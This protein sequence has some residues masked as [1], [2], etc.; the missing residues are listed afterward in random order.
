MEWQNLPLEVPPGFFRGGT[1]LASRGRWYDGNL[2]RWRDG[3]MQPVGGEAA[4]PGS[5][6]GN[7]Q[8][9]DAHAW[10]SR[11][12]TPLLA[13]GSGSSLRVFSDPGSVSHDGVSAAAVPSTAQTGHLNTE[14]WSL[15]NWGGD[16]IGRIPG[17]GTPFIVDFSQANLTADSLAVTDSDG[18]VFPLVAGLIATPERFVMAFGINAEPNRIAWSTQGLYD[19]NGVADWSA[20]LGDS[21]GGTYV[22]MK[23]E[24]LAGKRARGETLFWTTAELISARFIGLPYYYRF[25]I[26]GECTCISRR[27]M[28]VEG[29]RAFW[30]GRNNFWTYSGTVQRM[31]CD[32]GDLVF[33]E[34]NRGATSRI[35]CERRDQFAEV[36]WHY[37]SG[38]ST[39][40]DRYVT[41]NYALG[42]WYFGTSP[43][44]AGVDAGVHESPWSVAE[45]GQIHEMESGMVYRNNRIP[46]AKTGIVDVAEG[47]E[48]MLID[49]IYPDQS[50]S[51]ALEFE[52]ETADDVYQDPFDVHGPWDAAA[53]IDTRILA[54]HVQV[55]VRQESAGS[56]RYGLPRLRM[57]SAGWR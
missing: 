41:Y 32:V 38:S 57:Q 53:R 27:A 2:V 12:G 45:N 24:V 5:V 42:V 56:W 52:I 31:P 28:T 19:Q 36:T 10:V 54:R 6:G 20:S 30:M 40:C 46:F 49:T 15:D 11:T 4:K 1:P 3:V 50:T 17:V 22:G 44:Q 35:W 8:A 13:I 37:P 51:G 29:S 43:M 48:T 55:E 18:D 47:R 25:D 9:I 33:N 23:G 34:I 16:L 7:L 14:H 26:L 21:A 39:T